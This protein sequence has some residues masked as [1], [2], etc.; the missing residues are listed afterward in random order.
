MKTIGQSIIVKDKKHFLMPKTFNR[1]KDSVEVQITF[2]SSMKR[3]MD[4][5]SKIKLDSHSAIRNL[6]KNWSNK[7]YIAQLQC[8]I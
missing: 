7:D 8:Y 3:N 4:K 6:N 1:I 5:R 2:V